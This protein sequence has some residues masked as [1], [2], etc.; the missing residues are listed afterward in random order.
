MKTRE[1]ILIVLLIILLISG[2][3]PRKDCIEYEKQIKDCEL[4]NSICKQEQ[5]RLEMKVSLLNDA[6]D[7]L[8]KERN[9]LQEQLNL[10]DTLLFYQAINCRDSIKG[11][12]LQIQNQKEALIYFMGQTEK[13]LFFIEDTFSISDEKFFIIDRGVSSDTVKIYHEESIYWIVNYLFKNDTITKY[14][15]DF[16]NLQETEGHV[17]L[18]IN[19]EGTFCQ[20]FYPVLAVN[21]NDTLYCRSVIDH[22]QPILIHILKS[23]NEIKNISL[24]F[25]NDVVD[26]TCDRNITINSVILNKMEM[27]SIEVV[28]P[29]KVE[30]GKIIMENN[31]AKIII[32]P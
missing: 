30:G 4:E 7:L 17:V 27:D 28:L 1:N 20:G 13:A 21:V 22:T 14:E 18:I 5:K 11:L 10:C 29:A 8:V 19:A 32:T 2:C 6:K 3:N 24:E 9:N 23:Y 31:G 26:S 25:I 15:N 16:I 12:N